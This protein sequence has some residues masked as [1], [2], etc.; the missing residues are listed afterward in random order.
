[1]EVVQSRPS[2]SL[3]V[4]FS[5]TGSF[6]ESLE[7][8][9]LW[10][11]WSRPFFWNG[12]FEVLQM[13]GLRKLETFKVV[14]LLGR[15]YKSPLLGVRVWRWALSLGA[16]RGREEKLQ[17]MRLE[18]AIIFQDILNFFCFFSTLTELFKKPSRG[19]RR[20]FNA[21]GIVRS[22]CFLRYKTTRQEKTNGTI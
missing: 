10:H 12:K 9:T 5:K 15:K 20:R 19:A 17:E 13:R 7:S 4:S 21:N 11:T 8:N 18:L 16:L 6:S 14:P 22:R 3:L 2:F 1:M